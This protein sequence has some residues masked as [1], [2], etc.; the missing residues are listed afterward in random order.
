[1]EGRLTVAPM[2]VVRRFLLPSQP[3]FHTSSL[4]ARL[5]DRRSLPS[6]ERTMTHD[7]IPDAPELLSTHGPTLSTVEAAKRKAAYQAVDT[8]FPAKPRAVGIGSGSTVV[9]VVERIVQLG[10]ARLEGIIFV[11]TGYQSRELL[12]QGGLRVGSVDEHMEL[13]VVFD[14]K[15]DA[16]PRSQRPSPTLSSR[17]RRGGCRPELHQGRRRVSVPGKAGGH[18]GQEVCLCRR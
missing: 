18:P 8:H 15:S 5:Y 7:P 10:R 6:S 11:P 9:Y 17:R 13:D 4:S 3:L 12:V 14:G 1:M 16:Q 2:L